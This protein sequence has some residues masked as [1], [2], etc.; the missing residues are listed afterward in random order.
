MSQNGSSLKKCQNISKEMT[1]FMILH[2][3]TLKNRPLINKYFKRTKK[4]FKIQ[5]KESF[6]IQDRKMMNQFQKTQAIS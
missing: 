2:K 6:K 3:N 4:N 1:S 5:D